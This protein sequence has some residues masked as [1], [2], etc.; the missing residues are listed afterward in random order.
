MLVPEG[1]CRPAKL[2]C[3][4]LTLVS[5]SKKIPLT[6]N[7]CLIIYGPHFLLNPTSKYSGLKL[8][9]SDE[10]KQIF[11]HIMLYRIM[12]WY[13]DIKLGMASICFCVKIGRWK[14]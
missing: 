10:E 14:R 1:G 9:I 2:D 4:K 6:H 13:V 3:Q 7:Y 5:Y 12:I 8:C 11:T